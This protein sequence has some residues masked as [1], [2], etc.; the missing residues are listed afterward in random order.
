[1]L[2]RLR[3]YLRS[4]FR[5]QS[6][7]INI[8]SSIYDN[9]VLFLQ[10]SMHDLI[11]FESKLLSKALDDVAND[12]QLGYQILNYNFD[13]IKNNKPSQIILIPPKYELWPYLFLAIKFVS[14]GIEVN[15]LYF[16]WAKNIIKLLE[17]H[18]KSKEYESLRF[19]DVE[20]F[21]L[22]QGRGTLTLNFSE[23]INGIYANIPTFSTVVVSKH[24]D[25]DFALAYILNH[26]F[27]FAGLK[28][29]NIKRVI[30][31]KECE[32]TFLDKLSNR[33]QFGID[34]NLSQI[35]SQIFIDKM[36]QSILE[37]ISDGA[38]LFFGTPEFI[39]KSYP[40]NLIL[41]KITPNMSIF[42]K[43]IYGPLLMILTTDFEM[44]QLEMVLKKQPSKGII[45]FGDEQQVGTFLPRNTELYYVYR[46]PHQQLKRHNIIFEN[47][48]LEYVFESLGW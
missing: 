47:P 44:S 39:A 7:R 45:V 14:V 24:A 17:K 22:S 28:N 11:K 34:T 32:Q 15:F 33:I 30:L 18:K 26:A 9:L 5:N 13:G 20:E 31:D 43:K 21:T 41:N 10:V 35:T 46:Y 6:T 36:Q 4:L 12:F 19:F 3:N 37:A 38:E 23:S 27:S 42:Q 29:S 16:G 48:A 8:D 1:M 25:I 40:Q 2:N